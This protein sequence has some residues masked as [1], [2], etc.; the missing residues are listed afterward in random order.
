MVLKSEQ[1]LAGK[2]AGELLRGWREI[3]A[4]EVAIGVGN[5]AVAYGRERFIARCGPGRALPRRRR[6][7]RAIGYDRRARSRMVATVP[8]GGALASTGGLPVVR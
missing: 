3:G 6:G 8:P 2:A 4:N 7:R 1:I 5:P